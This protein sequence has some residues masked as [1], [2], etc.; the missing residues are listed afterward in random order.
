MQ[1]G[2]TKRVFFILTSFT[3]VFSL[4]LPF[5]STV[6]GASERQKLENIRKEINKNRSK[7]A[8]NEI[9]E[10][11]LEKEIEAADKTLSE[12]QEK[13]D[14]LQSEIDE[15][16]AKMRIV[17]GE[18]SE[19]NDQLLKNQNELNIALKDLRRLNKQLG[20]RAEEYYKN[21]EMSYIEVLL[22]AQSFIDFLNKADFLARIVNQDTKLLKEIKN[23]KV[24]VEASKKDIE[25]NEEDTQE[26]EA[27]LQTEIDRISALQ[28][29]EKKERNSL[30]SLMNDKKSILAKIGDEQAQIVA[31]LEAYQRD[32]LKLERAINTSP[33]RGGGTFIGTPSASGFQWPVQ[34]TL[35]SRFGTRWGRMHEGIDIG[36]P[37]GTPVVA[38]KSGVVSIARYYGGYGY[39]ID[40]DHG[41]GV[42]TRYGHNSRLIAKEGQAVS[43]GQE[44]SKAGSS[45][46][47]TG[48]HVHFEI[49]FN[50][51][52]YDPLNYLP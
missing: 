16:R 23:V 6:L 26:R 49:R 12:V 13:I 42:H 43:R 50:G 5:P 46:R 48:P 15:V 21:N 19:L 4:L 39:L 2:L 29:R 25:K 51:A 45:G 30:T 34:G 32:A 18:L 35:T 41:G 27:E 40:I 14:H 8:D 20:D 52:A 17:Q 1:I 31:K 10:S 37:T 36:V 38:A 7:S 11:Q 44:I 22:S 28:N 33:S 3:I 47:S 9:S 24:D